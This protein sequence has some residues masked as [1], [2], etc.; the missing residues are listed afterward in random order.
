M[1]VRWTTEPLCHPEA[2]GTGP[3]WYGEWRARI[4]SWKPLRGYVIPCFNRMILFFCQKC[5]GFE[6]AW[7]F[8]PIFLAQILTCDDCAAGSGLRGV[9]LPGIGKAGL[10]H[11]R[12]GQSLPDAFVFVPFS[13][14]LGYFLFFKLEYYVFFG[15]FDRYGSAFSCS[16]TFV[17][18]YD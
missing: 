5:R 12:E 6:Q 15:S 2:R 1:D 8:C 7:S 17:E 9:M 11:V 10:C 18:R 14:E 16:P 13:D 3:C 4:H